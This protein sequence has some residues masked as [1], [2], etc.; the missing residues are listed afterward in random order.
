M[1]HF[2]YPPDWP[3]FV[4]VSLVWLIAFG[5][6]AVSM[7][8]SL[9]NFGRDVPG[10]AVVM[11]LVLAYVMNVS[12]HQNPELRICFGT[13]TSMIMI[14][15]FILFAKFA[16][17]RRVNPRGMAVLG[18]AMIVI[19]VYAL[20]AFVGWLVHLGL[21]KAGFV[22]PGFIDDAGLAPLWLL[23]LVFLAFLAILREFPRPAAVEAAELYEKMG[24]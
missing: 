16:N 3:M 2:D 4:L 23:V 12:Y 20:T 18:L 5:R 9:A 8:G 14:A 21:F 10:L 15:L 22:P 19:G 17:W 6:L 11:P 7:K 13:Q 24:Y 1:I